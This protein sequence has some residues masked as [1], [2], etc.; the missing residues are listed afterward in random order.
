MGSG[1]C[2]TALIQ[3]DPNDLYKL[4]RDVEQAPMWQEQIVSVTRM[5]PTR[6]QW[7]MQSNG[8]QIE[9][10]SETPER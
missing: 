10:E 1:G 4:W 7:L 5:G 6:S 9:W 2:A 3:A 8:K